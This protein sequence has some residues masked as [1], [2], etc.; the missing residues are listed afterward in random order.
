MNT[1]PIL[2]GAGAK[3]YIVKGK[4]TGLHFKF[5]RALA[6]TVIFLSY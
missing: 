2:I 4:V 1:A 5:S 3:D 6:V